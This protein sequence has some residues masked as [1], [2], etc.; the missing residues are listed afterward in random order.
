MLAIA[1]GFTIIS[2]TDSALS[3]ATTY[4]LGASDVIIVNAF[5]LIFGLILFKKNK[6]IWETPE[7]YSLSEGLSA[8]K[9]IFDE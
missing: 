8:K 6:S 5:V 1:G 2:L 3:T 7:D 9:V 4:L